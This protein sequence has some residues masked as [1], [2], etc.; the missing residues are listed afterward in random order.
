MADELG[1]AFWDEAEQVSGI[2]VEIL[3]HLHERPEYVSTSYRIAIDAL[4]G[5]EHWDEPLLEIDDFD[6]AEALAERQLLDRSIALATSV[7]DSLVDAGS[8]ERY[9]LTQQSQVDQLLEIY[10]KLDMADAESYNTPY[11]IYRLGPHGRGG[12]PDEGP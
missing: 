5:S 8:V 10:P 2:R 4:S 9:R 6:S 1:E 11:Y 7:L 3:E 12:E